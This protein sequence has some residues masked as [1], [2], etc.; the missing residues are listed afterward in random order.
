M[1]PDLEFFLESAFDPIQP[2][3]ESIGRVVIDPDYNVKPDEQD[4][5]RLANELLECLRAHSGG[6]E[7]SPPKQY[8]TLAKYV[9]EISLHDDRSDGPWVEVT[10]PGNW[11]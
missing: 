6:K 1:N 7:F 10:P 8:A 4:R 11:I 5:T 3:S 2:T 9:R